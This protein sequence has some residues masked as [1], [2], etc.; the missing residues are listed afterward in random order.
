MIAKPDY[1]AGDEARRLV[2]ELLRLESRG[3]GDLEA[4]MRRLANRYGLPWRVFW[5]LRYR[6]QKDV[7]VGV[8]RKLQEAHRAECRRQIER[9]RHELSIAKLNGVHVED[10]EDQVS[11]LSA[12]LED[13]VADHRHRKP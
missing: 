6:K 4:A 13:C 1:S 12:E 7:F 9:L 3:S 5:N 8:L 2:N 10:L 11:T